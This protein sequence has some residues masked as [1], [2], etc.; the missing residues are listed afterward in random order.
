[1]LVDV[2]PN[3]EQLIFEIAVLG[4]EMSLNELRHTI[5]RRISDPQTVEVAVDLLIWTGCIGVQ[6]SHG[7]TYIS[8]CGFKRP[9][10]RALIIDPDPKSIV[11]HPT[12]ASVIAAPRSTLSRR[13]EQ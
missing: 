7:V 9:Y 5:S 11:F 4:S 8:D 10:M 2:V 13:S 1:M 6:T 12:L 3:A